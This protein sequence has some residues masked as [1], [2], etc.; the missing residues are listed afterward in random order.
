VSITLAPGQ[1]A[2][3]L[4]VINQGTTETSVQV[5]V[6]SWHQATGLDE[7]APSDS[8]LVS[9]PIITIP[10]GATQTVRVVIRKPDPSR[11]GTYRVLLDQIPSAAAAPGTIRIA[12]RLSIPVFAEPATRVAP[13][14][15][16]R[17][18][19]NAGKAMLV[20]TND[21]NSHGTMS[22]LALTTKSGSV[23]ALASTGTPYIL[24]GATRHWRIT[25]AGAGLLTPGATLQLTAKTNTGAIKRDIPVVVSTS[26]VSP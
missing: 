13:H 25:S 12:M 4:T 7:L 19:T 26:M 20:A 1:L 2:T 9:P 5:R 21:G 15:T 24:A 6:V 10:A 17:V 23:I 16:F 18:E 3:S 8:V 22:D 14:V 11:E